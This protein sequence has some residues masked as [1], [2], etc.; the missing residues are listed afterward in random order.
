MT[1][2]EAHHFFI[3]FAGNNILTDSYFIW[4][5]CVINSDLLNDLMAEHAIIS[6]VRVIMLFFAAL[7]T[8]TSKQAL[9]RL[10]HAAE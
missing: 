10:I 1:V 7:C 4:Y 3:D 8:N 9:K 5:I 6:A 2:R